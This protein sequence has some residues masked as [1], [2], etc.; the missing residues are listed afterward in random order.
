[1]WDRAPS[2]LNLRDGEVHVWRVALELLHPES[3]AGELAPEEAGRNFHRPP[4]RANYVVAHGALRRVLSRYCGIAPACIR[5]LRKARGKPYLD[6]ESS[7]RFNL[8]HS[9]GL[10]LIAVARECVVGVD[11]ERIRPMPDAVR[12][13]RRVLRP[14]EGDALEALPPDQRAEPFFVYWTRF[15]A[16][17]K[18]AGRALGDEVESERWPVADLEPGAGYAAAVAAGCALGR[19]MTWDYAD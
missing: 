15:E 8:S 11:V 17:L 2:D 9:G 4:D 18:A 7:V 6:P 3:F 16:R 1:M 5:F 12:I 19:V 14:E 10:A 13:A